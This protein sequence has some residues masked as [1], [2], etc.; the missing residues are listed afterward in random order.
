VT[1]R[2]PD[3]SPDA[4]WKRRFRTPLLGDLQVAS[5]DRRRAT[6]SSNASGVFQAYSLDLGGGGPRPRQ[7]TTGST[8][9]VFAHLSD[10]GRSVLTLL[11]EGGN[12]VGHWAGIPFEGGDAIDLT[13]G[14]APYSSW[15]VATSRDGAEVALAI[16]GDDGT[17]VWLARSGAEPLLLTSMWGLMFSLAFT[18][19]GATIVC[20]SAEPTRSNTYA[21][22]AIDAR[23]GGQMGELWDGGSSSM[24]GLRT[25][26]GDRRVAS[27]SN[28]SGR[29]RPLLWD[30]DTGERVDL[31][32]HVPGDVEVLDWSDD[33]ST[34]LFAVA[35]RGEE[36][37]VRYDLDSR[38]GEVV[39]VGGGS[40]GTDARFGT[41]GDIVVIRS[42]AT[43]SPRVVAVGPTGLRTIVGDDGAPAGRPWRSVSFPSSD[44]TSIQAW[45][46]VP[47]GNG[48][49]PTVLSV[50]GGPE[51]VTTDAYSPRLASW[52]D[53]G[54]AVCALN[55]RGSITFGREYQQAIWEDIGH[56]ETEDL[57]A[58]AA[59]LVEEG[60]ATPGGIVL[61]GGSYGGYLTLLGLGRLPELWAGGIALVA[62]ADWV[63][64][65]EESADAL[66][67]Y[68]DQ[69]FGGPPDEHPERYRVAS[70]ITYVG[71]LAAPLLVF[72][73]S[74]D[75]RCP[76][77][78]FRAY[79]EAA[80]AAGKSIECEWFDAGHIGPDTE[81]L[82]AFQ[83]R[84]LAFMHGIF[85]EASS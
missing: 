2:P 84:S 48:P 72:Q 16:T 18:A 75:T 51:S 19:D 47:E 35:D 61:T 21:L 13:P 7:L 42:R 44:G 62:V 66:R 11:D 28:L 6:M 38:S 55:Y 43:E 78:Q 8:G 17:D 71:E 31:E 4:V 70:P 36:S 3:T 10:D 45:V 85:R 50:H 9:T 5:G 23:T 53:H 29:A 15:A 49:Y 41:A 46:G 76:P 58:T 24:S 82:I 65:Y 26:P 33:A 68:Q 81:Q 25:A 1:P 32:L 64:M 54:Y 39:D 74:N 83:E 30:L 20:L 14:M 34:L 59:W 37:L 80:R 52:L 77:G 57:A 27:A 67:A 73:G 63:R 79:E 12:E 60:I 56:W 22:V 69:I 40:F